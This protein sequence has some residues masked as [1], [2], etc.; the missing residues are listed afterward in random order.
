M[1]ADF[2]RDVADFLALVGVRKGK[3]RPLRELVVGQQDVF[4][5]R[6]IIVRDLGNRQQ[7]RVIAGGIG[8]GGIFRATDL[9]EDVVD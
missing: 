7:L 8:A 9:D 6:Q 1:E 5:M 2:V 3:R 4:E